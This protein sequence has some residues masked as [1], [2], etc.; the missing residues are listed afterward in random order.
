[1][2]KKG[3]GSFQQ[4][5][6]PSCATNVALFKFECCILGLN[7]QMVLGRCSAPKKQ[8]D[9][10]TSL[11]KRNKSLGGKKRNGQEMVHS[12][13]EIKEELKKR[14]QRGYSNYVH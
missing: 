3:D 13:L 11:M 6:H 10:L 7:S 4:T 2:K 12:V 14:L 1:M 5:K 9:S 8:A